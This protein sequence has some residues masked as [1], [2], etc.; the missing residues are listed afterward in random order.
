MGTIDSMEYVL[1]QCA[2]DALCEKFHISDTVHPE[3]PGSKDM[4]RNS[5]TDEIGVY[6]RF[7]DFANY[8]IRLSHFLVDI[9]GYFQINLS[10]LLQP[11]RLVILRPTIFLEARLPVDSELS[12]S[13]TYLRLTFLSIVVERDLTVK[14]HEYSKDQS[15]LSS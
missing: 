6:S 7:F 15:N 4:T 3:L 9:F 12:Y 14:V 5:P 11:P 10:L 2:S 13:Q 8:R 1:T